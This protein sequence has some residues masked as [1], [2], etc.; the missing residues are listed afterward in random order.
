MTR[1]EATYHNPAAAALEE[2]ESV[3]EELRRKLTWANGEWAVELREDLRTWERVVA[4]L[5]GEDN[6]G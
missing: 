3:V 2:A 4:R 5:K 6:G 1:F